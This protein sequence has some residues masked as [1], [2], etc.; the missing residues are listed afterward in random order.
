MKRFGDFS[1]YVLKHLLNGNSNTWFFLT[2]SKRADKLTEYEPSKHVCFH[3]SPVVTWKDYTCLSLRQTK[4]TN[5]LSTKYMNDEIYQG[6][7]FNVKR[8]LKS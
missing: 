7:C 3:I 2:I 1:K 5:S 6:S 8:F 4:F